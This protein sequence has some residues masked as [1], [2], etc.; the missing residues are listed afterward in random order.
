M[1]PISKDIQNRKQKRAT[2]QSCTLLRLIVRTCFGYYMDV[3]L[4]FSFLNIF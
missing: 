3:V 4:L 1:I 2:H